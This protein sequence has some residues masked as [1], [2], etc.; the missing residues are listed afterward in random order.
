MLLYF[1]Y[2][3]LYES[4]DKKRNKLAVYRC[5]SCPGINVL[6]TYK[7]GTAVCF[8]AFTSTSKNEQVA[9]SFMKKGLNNIIFQ[10]NYEHTRN[11]LFSPRKSIYAKN[12]NS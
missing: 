5:V 12:N 4:Q 1:F 10:I 6:E 9:K 3:H 8:P 11:Q 2:R 7:F